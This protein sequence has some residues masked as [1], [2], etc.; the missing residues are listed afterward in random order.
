MFV[1]IRFI[2][3]IYKVLF[4][5]TECFTCRKVSLCTYTVFYILKRRTV[6]TE[7]NNFQAKLLEVKN[8]SNIYLNKSK[9]NNIRKFEF[10]TASKT[11]KQKH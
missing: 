5:K 4:L 10:V 9:T 2:I 3:R 1:L 11:E 7:P 6:Q 8:V